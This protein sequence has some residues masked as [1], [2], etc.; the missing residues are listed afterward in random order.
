MPDL[1]E[2]E[3]KISNYYGFMK[4]LHEITGKNEKNILNMKKK[5]IY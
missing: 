4:A 3:K 5:K 2:T 1:V